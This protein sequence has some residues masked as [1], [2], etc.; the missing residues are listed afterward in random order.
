MH[1]QLGM[2]SL[3]PTESRSGVLHSNL[4]V[5]ARAVPRRGM[6]RQ[7][8]AVKA[9]VAGL[10][11]GLAGFLEARDAANYFFTYRWMLII[12]KRELAF[13]EVRRPRCPRGP[14]SKR[15]LSNDRLELLNWRF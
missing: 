12:F 13:D 2:I 11:P 5:E 14:Q 3:D 9:L 1:R 7:L 6:H 4:T 10:D 8:G 15:S